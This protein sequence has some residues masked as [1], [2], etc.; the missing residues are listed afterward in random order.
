MT[1]NNNS[2]KLPI[3]T[4]LGYGTAEFSSTL[5]WTMVS[6]LF[7]FFLTDVVGIE[8]AFAGLIL[9]VGTLWDGVTD[10][11]VGILSDRLKSRWGRR[12]PF[13]LIV[14]VPFG[15]ITWLLF[16]DFGLGEWQTKLYFLLAIVAYYTAA[17]LLDVP[18]TSL[19]A[20]MTQ[21]YDERTTLNAY[22]GIFSQVASICAAALPW[23]LVE[24]L[25]EWTGS[26]ESGWSLMS[27][28]F[29]ICAVFPILWAWRATRGYELHPEQT[30]V[31]IRDILNGPLKN[32]TFLY[33]MALYA[34]GSVGLSLAGAVMVY[35]MK[36]YLNFDG[37]Q[38]SIAFLFLFACTIFWIP[39]INRL[40]T[41]LGKRE[42][43]IIFMGIWGVVQAIGVFFLQPSM[44]ILFYV[45]MIIASGGVM[46]ISMTGWA[47][48]PDA[49]E[50]DQFKT[51]QRREGL[52][53]GVILFSRKFSVAFVLWIVGLVLSWSGYIPNQPQSDQAIL[54]IRLLYAEGTAFFLLLSVGLAYLLPMTRKR[55]AALKEAIEL[56][57]QGKQWDES[58]LQAI[59]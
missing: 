44:M 55:H 48:I 29:G 25:A 38:E 8:P 4:K 40:S 45:L 18:Y 2:G 54:G 28:I 59:L 52:Y 1:L 11:S 36:Y 24:V 46:T 14:A 41:T 33:T 5:T 47:L 30:S 9:M 51:G 21:D 43:F 32:R 57:S 35:Y 6:V 15:L 10:P 53:V 50:V 12:R 34:A 7:L 37:T 17:T 3:K 16:S 42:S 27:G 22:R 19:A 26:V 56:K 23:V 58:K 13:L 49:I 20:E 31:Q 39:V